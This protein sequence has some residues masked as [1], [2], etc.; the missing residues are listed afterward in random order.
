MRQ[1]HWIHQRSSLKIGMV[2]VVYD[3]LE[4]SRGVSKY[5][6]HMKYY[7]DS[8]AIRKYMHVIWVGQKDARSI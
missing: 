6:P 5:P 4:M 1:H 3:A 7:V 2:N 8:Q